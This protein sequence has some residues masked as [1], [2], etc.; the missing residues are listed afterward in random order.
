[1][2]RNQAVKLLAEAYEDAYRLL[3]MG[4]L[5]TG[6][7]IFSA[8]LLLSARGTLGDVVLVVAHELQEIAE[9]DDEEDAE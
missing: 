9:M 1:M 8:L 2:T 5:D 7:I 3:P 6:E 4:K